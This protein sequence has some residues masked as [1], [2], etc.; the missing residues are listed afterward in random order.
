MKR[1]STLVGILLILLPLTSIGFLGSKMM[2]RTSFKP[3]GDP[4]IDGPL[5][6]DGTVNDSEV[7]DNYIYLVG[8]F[9]KVGRCLSKGAILDSA[10]QDFA[11]PYEM[12][13]H[14]SGKYVKK[15]IPDGSGGW[16][17]GGDFTKARGQT[18]NNLLRLSSDGTLTAWAPNPN[19]TVNDLFLDSGKLYV[20]GN[21]NNIAGQSRNGIAAFD[22]TTGNLLAL[23]PQISSSGMPYVYNIMPTVST[24]CFYGSISSATGVSHP[25]VNHY[26]IDRSTLNYVPLDVGVSDVSAALGTGSGSKVYLAASSLYSSSSIGKIYSGISKH[27]SYSS[28]NWTEEFPTLASRPQVEGTVYAIEP[29]GAGGYFIGGSFSKV[30]SVGRTNFAH[31]NSSGAVSSINLSSFGSVTGCWQTA[32]TKIVRSGTN[33]FVA[34]CFSNFGGSSRN[35]VALINTSGVLQ[36]WNP[37]PDQ[38]VHE[39]LVANGKI[40][41]G[42]SF[43]T[44][45]ST[46]RNRLAVYDL[47]TLSLE[48]TSLSVDS[49]EVRALTYLSGT[50]YVGGNFTSAGGSART[51]LAAFDV[52]LAQL[53][54]WGPTVDGTV[55]VLKSDAS[56]IYVGGQFGNINSFPRT[57]FALFDSTGSLQSWSPTLAHA[58]T[59]SLSVNTIYINASKLFIGGYFETVDSQP[60]RMLASFDKGTWTLDTTSRLTPNSE[61]LA[62]AEV[63]TSLVTGGAFKTLGKTLSTIESLDVSSGVWE[64]IY[65]VP[66][67]TTQ[68]DD[69]RSMAISG[70]TLYFGGGFLKVAPAIDRDYVAAIDIPTKTLTSFS[71]DLYSPPLYF[72]GTYDGIQDMTIANGKLYV[73][74]V[75]NHNSFGGYYYHQAIDLTTAATLPGPLRYF[76]RMIS[77]VS[78]QGTQVM[79][80]GFFGLGE[81][82]QNRKSFAVIE[83][84]SGKLMTFSKGVDG[85][86]P[87]NKIAIYGSNIYIAGGFN[88][89]F[90]KSVGRLA[91]VSRYTGGI[92]NWNP[93]INASSSSDMVSALWV[94]QTGIY[95]SGNSITSAGGQPRTNFA[96]YN[97]DGTLSSWNPN[98]N[99][100]VSGIHVKNDKIF[101]TGSFT[102]I[103]STARNYI[104]SFDVSTK[105][106]G[107]WA[108]TLNNTGDSFFS[109]NNHLWLSGNFS[110]V[111]GVS[112]PGVVRF[113]LS[114]LSRDSTNVGGYSTS[115]SPLV[116]DGSYMYMGG[117]AIRRYT[118][119]TGTNSTPTGFSI[120]GM[121]FSHENSGN[122]QQ[123]QSLKLRDN[124]LYITGIWDQSGKNYNN[125][126]FGIWNIGTQEWEY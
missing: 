115:R 119:A 40:F 59:W 17:V 30:N 5:C 29:D 58:L 3:W 37:S 79:V 36:S 13:P 65:Q 77:A 122:S 93:A 45:S 4:S 44:I 53:L 19:G 82:V 42:G 24:I 69:I 125:L 120:G 98:P 41:L 108:P 95:V 81:A 73:V 49:G 97:L 71:P 126:G 18:R 46:A 33:V 96:H 88:T 20:V 14:M 48:T 28:G 21:F 43:T 123:A 103:A 114:D 51:H 25:L 34:G 75:M 116:V 7:D 124:K 80:G 52:G 57:R 107:S 74:G 121:K 105:T 56:Y 61:V 54:S 94:D 50:L 68:L 109:D 104:A 113:N 67:G 76:D 39:I 31:I 15:I 64:T 70:N 38:R 101:L 92:S 63:G 90:G 99:T 85:S 110:T 89:F 62:I 60:S 26:C 87:I 6:F 23:N 16:Y 117:T 84:S 118:H 66:S 55:L 111:D 22:T 106:L 9:N 12:Q 83:K 1:T 32:V 27:S 10:M 78:A 47:S 100:M 35:S 72:S 91:K 8:Y 2:K 102:N 86:R 112:Y 11:V